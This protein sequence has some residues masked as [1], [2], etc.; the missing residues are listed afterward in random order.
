MAKNTEAKKSDIVLSV[1]NVDKKF[2]DIPILKGVTFDIKRGSI[3][4]LVGMNGAGKTTLVKAIAGL[5]SPDSGS[6]DILG[7]KGGSRQARAVTSV[8]FDEPA[9]YSDLTVMEHL[10]FAARLSGFMDYQERADQLLEEFAI[11]ELGQRLPRGFSRGQRQK[12]ALSMGLVRS[13]K[14][15]VLDEPYAGLDASG[16]KALLAILGDAATSGAA[17]L[18]ATHAPELLAIANQMVTISD[19]KVSYVGKPDI[20][21]IDS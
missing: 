12:T 4:C 2:D 9:L 10:S 8:V 18:I 13:F 19:G 21:R 14:L 1:K 16:K 7:A 17:V 11:Q 15:L 6:I 5:V 20:G 3:C